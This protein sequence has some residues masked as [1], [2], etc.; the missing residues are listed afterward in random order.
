MDR[1][2]F[3]ALF[4][5]AYPALRRY[6]LHR[7]LGGAD[8]D[9]LAAAALEVAWRRFDEVPA[10]AALPWLYGVARNLLRNQARKDRRH[11]VLLARLTTRAPQSYDPADAGAIRE[12]L[13][14]LGEEDRELL[15]L[16]AWD[17]LSPSEAAVALGCS[18]AAARTRLHR[19]RNRL[20]A[21][22]GLDVKSSGRSV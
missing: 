2:A 12:A 5:E 6:A 16:V 1:T 11:E 15:K 21:R 7:G 8:A 9:D 22:L 3:R 13:E 20:A 10:D 4:Q 17:G 14:A 19:A 18:A